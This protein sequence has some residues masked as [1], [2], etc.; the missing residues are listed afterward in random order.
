MYTNF[1]PIFFVTD[2]D[3]LQNILV[4]DFSFFH[5]RGNYHDPKVEPLTGHLFNVEGKYWKRLRQK[6]TPSLTT[7]KLRNMIPTILDICDKF[8]VFLSKTIRENSE[9]D[10]HD[11][12]SRFSCDIIGSCAFGIECNSM[13]NKESEFL[14]MGRAIF[15]WPTSYSYR[16]CRFLK[17]YFPDVYRVF[18]IKTIRPE[19]EAF[20]MNLVKN[21]IEYRQINNVK[22]NDFIDLLLNIDI[23][24]GEIDDGMNDRPGKLSF[25]QIAAQSFI[26]FIAVNFFFFQKLINFY[27]FTGF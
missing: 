19:I 14:K 7:G 26:F 24:N 6:M 23:Q 20:F 15:K 18:Q 4:K 27:F 16:I 9:L 17:S 25:G 13:D 3:L 2:L 8:E 11:V 5:D 10:V 1:K 12:F 22:R 21:V